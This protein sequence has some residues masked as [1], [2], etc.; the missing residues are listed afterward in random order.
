MINNSPLQQ[1]VQSIKMNLESL[2]LKNREAL[3]NVKDSIRTLE[4]SPNRGYNSD[5][6]EVRSWNSPNKPLNYD[7]SSVK[8]TANFNYNY[9]QY[10][11]YS[12]KYSNQMNNIKV[13]DTKNDDF[14][15]D[16][17]L[18]NAN[19]KRSY[20]FNYSSPINSHKYSHF[21]NS[22]QNMSYSK[23]YKQ[24]DVENLSSHIQ[25][26]KMQLSE[27][28]K[29]KLDLEVEIER[30]KRNTIE[31]NQQKDDEISD[32]DFVNELRKRTGINKKTELLHE[33]KAKFERNKIKEEFISKTT[34]VCKQVTG[35]K[36]ANLIHTWRWI[37]DIV[38]E[39]KDYNE[40]KKYLQA[41]FQTDNRD[42]KKLIL[43]CIENTYSNKKKV[44]KIKKLLLTE[45][46]S[47]SCSGGKNK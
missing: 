11:D 39:A 5:D 47:R 2:Q 34:K 19:Q 28:E 26:L 7:Y 23:T 40:V 43:S 18:E 30:T 32:N 20:N 38:M 15:Y 1:Q 4:A 35:L 42:V 45:P 9:P 8:D 44:G 6:L 31:T 3:N 36:N 33:I 24:V 14:N 41:R 13:I 12:N 21:Q 37:K 27:L 17:R 46:N 22:P 10:E 29:A 16:Y 25:Q